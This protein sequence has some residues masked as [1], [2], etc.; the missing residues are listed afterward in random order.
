MFWRGRYP[1]LQFLLFGSILM[2]VAIT[3]LLTHHRSV[4]QLPWLIVGGIWIV[5]GLVR[6]FQI[7]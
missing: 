7:R 4:I 3:L 1:P 6:L 2:V 5:F